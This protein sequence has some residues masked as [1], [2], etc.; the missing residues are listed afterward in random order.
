MKKFLMALV[1]LAI[2]SAP[3]LAGPNDCG[4]IV[5]HNTNMA[6]SNDPAP[7][8]PPTP[9]P[10]V[11]EIVNTIP[12][13]NQPGDVSANLVWKV[14]AAFPLDHSPRVKTCGWGVA[15]DEAGGGVVIEHNDAQNLAVFYITSAGWPGDHT[16]VGMS[17]TD[18][19]RVATVNELWWFSGY[20]YAG[21]AGEP[22]MF[23][24]IPNSAV[25]N[26]VF[27]DDDFPT[28]EDPITGY[29]TLGFGQPGVTPI[30][31]CEVVGACCFENG[32]CLMLT[33]ADCSTQ[34]G[35][36]VGGDCTPGLCI[37]IVYGACCVN[38]VCNVVTPDACA[39]AEGT[40]Y[41]DG[42]VCTP[43]TCPYIPTENKSWGQIK[44]SY[45]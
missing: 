19:A 37:P 17:F 45:R 30:P 15:H 7:P 5:V 9:V 12:M 24:V 39:Q 26:Q 3:A 2:A 6:Y 11:A 1:V 38:Y 20:A 40:Y 10:A 8:G 36:F 27:G 23:S 44:N 34:L 28:N 25:G 13:G 21:L 35:S 33:A 4:V 22:Q 18:S 29:G 32:D 14:Y 42:S 41:G 43:D 16:Y 31:Q